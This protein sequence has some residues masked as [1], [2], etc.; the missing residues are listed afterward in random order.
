[1]NAGLIAAF[2]PIQIPRCLG[3][4]GRFQDPLGFA[5]SEFHGVGIALAVDRDLD[6]FLAVDVRDARAVLV[7]PR[8]RGHLGQTLANIV[9][10]S[11]S[12][13]SCS[14]AR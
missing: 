5:A 11:I 7:G 13:M 12:R 10:I 6:A 2:V 4:L 9:A 1:M 8:D 3:G 14:R